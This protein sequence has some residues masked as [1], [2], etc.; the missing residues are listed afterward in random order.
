[1]EREIDL[2]LTEVG[3]DV[4]VQINMGIIKRYNTPR[5]FLGSTSVQT[6]QM[7]YR[8]VMF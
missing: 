2:E 6:L 4:V 7:D 5:Y 8:K 3:L 1:M